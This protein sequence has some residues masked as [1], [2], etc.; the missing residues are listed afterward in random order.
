MQPLLNSK[1]VFLGHG[2]AKKQNK[3]LTTVPNC[4]HV[5]DFLHGT[6]RFLQ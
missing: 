2:K 3:N 6:T 4:T 1:E 5:C